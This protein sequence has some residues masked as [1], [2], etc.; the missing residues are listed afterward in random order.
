MLKVRYCE[1]FTSLQ[2]ILTAHGV[3]VRLFNNVR[4][5]WAK[6]YCPVQ[7][8]PGKL[9]KFYYDPD[10]LR[11]EP[12]RRTGDGVLKSFRGLGT[13]RRSP[14]VLDG[15]NVVASRNKAIV[16]EKVYKENP[17]CSQADLRDSLQKLLQVDQLIIIPKEPCDPIG[18]ADGMV[19][20]IDENSV[21]V[22]DYSEVDPGFGERLVKV[23]RRHRLTIKTLA[24]L[25]EKRSRDGIPSA[26][27]CYTNFLRTEKV[28]VAPIYGTKKD[29]VALRKLEDVFPRLPIVPLNCTGLARD[30]GVLNCVSAT[31]Q[32]SPQNPAMA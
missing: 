19:R 10:Y 26:V 30:G 2:Q 21:L 7:V 14:I 13:C 5:I 3:A 27:G 9:V 32:V 4:D 12:T 25:P 22:N 18:H 28:L 16:T 24:Y 31:Y 17:G 20:F 6:D 23:L 11:E 1:L 8:G 15:G 29:R